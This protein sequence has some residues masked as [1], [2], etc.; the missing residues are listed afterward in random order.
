LLTALAVFLVALLITR[1]VSLSSLLGAAILVPATWFWHRQPVLLAFS[2]ALAA[3][4]VHRHRANIQR[5]LAGTEPRLG[6]RPPPPTSAA[7]S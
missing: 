6:R 1:I 5:L 2:V 7:P 3:L 4:A